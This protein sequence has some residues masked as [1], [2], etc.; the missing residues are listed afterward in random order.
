MGS[1]C[2]NCY[3]LVLYLYQYYQIC[4][5]FLHRKTMSKYQLN[6]VILSIMSHGRLRIYASADGSGMI[7]KYVAGNILTGYPDGSDK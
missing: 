3:Y 4:I 7:Y 2:G 5:C 1:S 6:G